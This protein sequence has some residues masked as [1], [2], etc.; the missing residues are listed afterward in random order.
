VNAQLLWQ[1][2]WE[3]LPNNSRFLWLIRNG[4]RKAC[5]VEVPRS[6]IT[7]P[8]YVFLLILSGVGMPGFCGAIP[9]SW[10]CLPKEDE[11]IYVSSNPN[12]V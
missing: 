4:G 7:K 12:Q 5:L 3:A 6:Y 11:P 9:Q 1:S 8:I 2:A 10:A